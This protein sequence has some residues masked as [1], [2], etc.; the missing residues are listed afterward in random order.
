MLD[1]ETL[2]DV[3][4]FAIEFSTLDELITNLAASILECAE[5]DTAERLTA[6]FTLGRKLDLIG[7]VSKQLATTYALTQPYDTLLTQVGFAKRLV[8]DR[9]A[10]LHGSLTIRRG[11]HPTVQA[12]K[13]KVELTP[14]KLSELVG[15]IDSAI[16][17]L[18][19]AYFG[20]MDAVCKARAAK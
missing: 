15:R 14:S 4:R 1:N 10:V 18:P 12:K 20:F 17:G 9:N 6:N 13:D 19:P 3:G 11:E 8:V 16:D 7:E 2:K 5:W